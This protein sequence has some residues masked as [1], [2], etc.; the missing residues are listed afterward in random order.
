MESVELLND[1]C[2]IPKA[3]EY[4]NKNFS[5]I[6]NLLNGKKTEDCFIEASFIAEIGAIEL[7]NSRNIPDYM[8]DAYKDSFSNSD[9][10]LLEHYQ[11][12]LDN[13]DKSLLGFINNLK[14]KVFEFEL[15]GKLEN[16]Y[17]GFDFNLAD[18]P[19]Q[20]IWDLKGI[21][22]YGEELL[23]QAKLWGEGSY[24]K[25][26]SLMEENPNVLYAASNEIREKVLQSSPELANQFVDIDVN[27]Y[28]FTE[29]VK[30]NLE[31]LVNNMG[32]DVPD[33]LGDLLPYISEIVLGM[34]LIMDLIS[35]QRDFKNI[36]A[37]DKAKLSAVKVIVLLSRYGVT[38]GCTTICG[39]A[40]GSLGGIIPGV[41]NGLGGVAGGIGGAVL[42]GKINKEIKPYMLDISLKLVGLDKEDMFYFSNKK[43]I[44]NLAISYLNTNI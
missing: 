33:G 8:F 32:I 18:S 9:I 39:I 42:A 34:R 5:E 1:I 10:S 2:K 40:G 12:M 15:E 11:Q 35:V 31:L 29:G 44:D 28:E 23:V 25:L 21:N 30:E 14:G 43:L 19:T 27:N 37:E 6:L 13:G 16:L 4:E 3:T 20:P 24:S 17:P 38:L 7:F 26:I 22:E 36:S 41:G